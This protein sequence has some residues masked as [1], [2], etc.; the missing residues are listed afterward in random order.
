MSIYP[1]KKKK[2]TCELLTNILRDTATPC[3]REKL[4]G[5]WRQRETFLG[6]VEKMVDS[7]NDYHPTTR[8]TCERLLERRD[9]HVLPHGNLLRVSAVDKI[10]TEPD[11]S[12]ASDVFQQDKFDFTVTPI[13]SNTADVDTIDNDPSINPSSFF[14]HPK[15]GWNWF[16]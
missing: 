7:S 9:P 3:F 14:E 5:F 11:Q 6:A 2:K 10:E 12:K 1:R 13:N 16:S 15:R 4:L 8:L